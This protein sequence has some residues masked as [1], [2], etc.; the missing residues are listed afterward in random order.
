MKSSLKIEEINTQIAT[1]TSQHQKLVDQRTSEIAHLI[2]RVG[3]NSVEDKTLLGGF[4]HM[5]TVLST[6]SPQQ[7]AWRVA[8]QK[9]LRDTRRTHQILKPPHQTAQKPTAFKPLYSQIES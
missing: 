5:V 8:G 1:L 7:E 9:F 4:L 3:L 6:P 2:S